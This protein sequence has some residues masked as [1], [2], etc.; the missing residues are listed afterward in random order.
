MP[1][2]PIPVRLFSDE[3]FH[4]G[5]SIPSRLRRGCC[6]RLFDEKLRLPKHPKWFLENKISDDS[7]KILFTILA[8]LLF[9]CRGLD[10]WATR[11]HCKRW[12][13]RELKVFLRLAESWQN[14]EASFASAAARD[15][16][17]SAERWVPCDYQLSTVRWFCSQ[18]CSR[19]QRSKCPIVRPQRH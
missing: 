4:P 14:R 8:Y 18:L 9:L 12:H 1:I 17:L 15:L 3:W 6:Q 19:E 5:C 2:R 7:A 16:L 11:S 10:E 13:Y